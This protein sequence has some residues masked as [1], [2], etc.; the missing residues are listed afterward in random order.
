[1]STRS[2]TAGYDP[3]MAATL[4]QDPIG[5]MLTSKDRCD[6]CNAQA[7]VR[8]QLP[9]GGELLFCAH[10]GREHLPALEQIEGIWIHDE[11]DRLNENVA[12]QKLAKDVG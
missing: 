4:V 11:R 3:S 9:S 1:M 2:A 10:H 8:A 6:R 12:A 5:E 7:Y